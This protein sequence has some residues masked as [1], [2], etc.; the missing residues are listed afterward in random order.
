MNRVRL[1]FRKL[2][3]IMCNCKGLRSGSSMKI[4]KKCVSVSLL[5][6]IA[7][8]IFTDF[9]TEISLLLVAVSYLGCKN[10]YYLRK[11]I[12]CLLSF[13]NLDSIFKRKHKR[14][15]QL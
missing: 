14:E 2:I 9:F 8:R 13:L 3:E 10:L 7:I 12:M 11:K 4:Q 15:T 6:F 1:W 5:S